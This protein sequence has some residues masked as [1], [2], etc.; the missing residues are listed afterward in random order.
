MFDLKGVP[1]GWGLSAN[2]GVVDS[3][4]FIDTSRII[5]KNLKGQ[6]YYPESSDY[7]SC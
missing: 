4:G 2:I 5:L 1:W 6:I 3:N 7:Y